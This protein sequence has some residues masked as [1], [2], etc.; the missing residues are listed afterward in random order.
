VTTPESPVTDI[1]I[2]QLKAQAS[3]ILDEVREQGARYVI[4]RRGRPV[5]VLLPI[6]QVPA[7]GSQR[8]E[9]WQE[10]DRLGGEI[11]RGWTSPLSSGEILSE[12]RR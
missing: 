11:G 9:V 4:T 10:L 6:E 7:A 12:L 3:K 5:G 1:G 2:R 8:A